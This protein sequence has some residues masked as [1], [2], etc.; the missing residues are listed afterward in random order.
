[1]KTVLTATVHRPLLKTRKNLLIMYHDFLCAPFPLLTRQ[2]SWKVPCRCIIL[3]NLISNV[4]IAM[5]FVGLRKPFEAMNMETAACT[6]RC[7]CPFYTIFLP[8]FLLYT[9]PMTIVGKV[10]VL[11]YDNII[12]HLLSRPQEAPVMST[13][14]CSMDMVHHPIK[15]KANC[16]I[17]WALFNLKTGEHHC[18]ASYTFTILVRPCNIART[19]IHIAI[20]H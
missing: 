10:F 18:T 1:M 20:P 11:T 9:V 3:A 17:N 16:I 15:S 13:A 6:E 5:L 2:R 8:T 7:L 14:P 4:H 12:R 19:T